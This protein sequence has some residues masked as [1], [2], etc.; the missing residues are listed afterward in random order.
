MRLLAALAASALALSVTAA[1]ASAGDPLQELNKV[2]EKYTGKKPEPS[3]PTGASGATGASGPSGA[4]GVLQ[5]P[6]PTPEQ[7]AEMEAWERAMTPG[8]NHRALDLFAGTWDAVVRGWDGTNP[9]PS[10][11]K[12]VMKTQW[13]LGNR[14]LEQRFEGDFMGQPFSGIGYL[15]Y[16][17]IRG[18]HLGTWMDTMSTAAMIMRGKV[19]SSGQVITFKGEMS[20]AV[21]GKPMAVR[22]ELRILTNDKHVFALYGPDKAG[23]EFKWMEITYTRRKP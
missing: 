8:M 4:T 13:V 6:A 10:E 20:D 18:E 19:D 3:G 22:E 17:N 5:P 1:P 12:G 15:G 23:K 11:S 9:K 2:L 21:S 14:W 7:Q 16:D